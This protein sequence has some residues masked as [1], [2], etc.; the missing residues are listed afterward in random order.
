M[1]RLVRASFGAL[2]AFVSA[3][4][5]LSVC[6]GLLLFAGPLSFGFLS[7]YVSDTLVRNGVPFR[8]TFD[9]VQLRWDSHGRRLRARLTRGALYDIEGAPIAGLSDGELGF[10]GAELLTGR[11]VLTDMALTAPRLTIVR[12]RD[13]SLG[14]GAGETAGAASE[15]AGL[16][17]L[18][19]F[20]N[21]SGR[22][23]IGALDRF[24][25][26][27][28]AVTLIDEA[29]GKR[30]ETA[31]T[32]LTTRI[33]G[34]EARLRLT[35]RLELPDGPMGADLE[36]VH[37][38]GS[39][40]TAIRFVFE[41]L[42]AAGLDSLLGGD[43]PP[44]LLGLDTRLRGRLVTVLQADGGFSPL[45]VELRGEEG[46]VRLP[47]IAADAVA[48]R[49][50]QLDADVAIADRIARVRRFE[51]DL[52]DAGPV[53]FEG[54]L[55]QHGEDF[56]IEGA[57]RLE[58]LDRDR[59]LR[60]WPPAFAPGARRWIEAHVGAAD[61]R[62]IALTLDLP[63]DGRDFAS[64]PADALVLTWQF[65][66]GVSDYLPPLPALRQARGSGRLDLQRLDLTVAAA[67]AEAL[68][69]RDGVLAIPDLQGDIMTMDLRFRVSGPAEAAW[70]VIGRAPLHFTRKLGLTEAVAGGRADFDVSLSLPLLLSLPA[71]QVRASARGRLEDFALSPVFGG[72]R[73]EQGRLDLEV[74]GDGLAA[75]GTARL[76][77]IPM[78]IRWTR[79]F[80]S[81]E[82]TD[83]FAV[84][85]TLSSQE[86]ARRGIDA[87]DSLD[88]P[89]SLSATV[90]RQADG[91]MAISGIADLYRARM[92]FPALDW[93]KPPGA[94]AS[95]AFGASVHADGRTV[96]HALDF[97]S[98]DLSARGQAWLDTEGGLE[99]L[100]VKDLRHRENDFSAVFER[101]AAGTDSLRLVGRQVDLRPLLAARARERDDPR[102][103]RPLALY[104]ESERLILDDDLVAG[105]VD[106]EARRQA[107]AWRDIRATAAFGGVP[108][109]LMGHGD[110]SDLLIELRADDAGAL[111]RALDFTQAAEGGDLTL[112]LR[113]P[114]DPDRDVGG[115]LQ[116]R[117]LKLRDAPV[118]AQV[119]SLGS[120][121]GLLDV[122][123]GEGITFDWLDAPFIRSADGLR[124]ADARAAG[125]ALGVAVSGLYAPASGRIDLEGTVV[126]AYTLSTAIG[127]IP[128]VGSLLAGQRGEGVLAIR[129]TASGPGDDPQVAVNPLTALAPGILRDIIEGFAARAGG[130][131]GAEAGAG[132]RTKPE[133]R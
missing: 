13:G 74:D 87:G 96:L 103:G 8:L 86:L 121:T 5:V 32:A 76:D 29:S 66:G 46:S 54:T 119:L 19:G 52:P 60:Y 14:L 35:G 53:R 128:L 71:E 62:D 34:E 95:L 59:L 3:L 112:L 72:R 49:R 92:A 24:T 10:D 9:D 91:G 122:L 120:V 89:V 55:E 82:G 83:R 100:S 12:R 99:R 90:L 45:T 4:A 124:F 28:A 105:D 111:G 115:S 48:F 6:V 7:G 38:A 118:L 40:E 85:A 50:L 58:T 22:L 109:R 68:R 97:A 57:V 33:V 16:R 107:G 104:L 37:D 114:A 27:G 94:R 108:V 17:V 81:A 126:P 101:H 61:L 36:L 131:A 39:G 26:A 31:E 110:G 44:A 73:L 133:G 11:L 113:V 70:Q 63:A 88:G 65:S 117:D 43:L 41:N 2:G 129:F 123:G 77:G 116:V 67:E 21:P 56:G 125:P 69:V 42:N 78:S 20:A 15:G 64:R 47:G 80:G 51:V 1:K 23:A 127:Q 30:F 130:P 75:S 25:I 93:R 79:D 84:A 106:L 132:E 102:A 98:A 18:Q